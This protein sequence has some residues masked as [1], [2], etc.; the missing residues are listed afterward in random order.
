VVGGRSGQKDK[1]EKRGRR[2]GGKGREG[3]G[4]TGQVEGMGGKEERRKRGNKEKR[5]EGKRGGERG[6]REGRGSTHNHDELD[7]KKQPPLWIVEDPYH[8]IPHLGRVSPP[9]TCLL[10]SIFCPPYSLLSLPI[11]F[12][13]LQTFKISLFLNFA[14][15]N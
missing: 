13:I 4:R 6:R 3:R 12:L 8:E 10:S 9:C 2:E 11:T 15:G 14:A 5:K 7:E 1:R